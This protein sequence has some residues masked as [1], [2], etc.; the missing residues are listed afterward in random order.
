MFLQNLQ[1]LLVKIANNMGLQKNSVKY[2]GVIFDKK[3]TRRLH[4]ETVES[5]A[6]ENI[7]QVIFPAEKWTR[8][9]T[10]SP[11]FGLF[12]GS[13][14]HPRFIHSHETVKNSTGPHRNRSKMA[15]ETSTQSFF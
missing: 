12:S 5:K 7:S 4:I 13:Y 10:V 6:L 14:V 2:L 8:G 3:N 9:T 15:C 11:V 1:D